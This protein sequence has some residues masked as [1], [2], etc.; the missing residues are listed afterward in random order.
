LLQIGRG[1]LENLNMAFSRPIPLSPLL[2][3]ACALLVAR[4]SL[5]RGPGESSGEFL[6]IYSDARPASLGDAYVALAEN[7]AGL[8][9]NPAGL[10]RAP[11]REITAS[12]VSW[13][14]EANFQHIA[15]THP[16]NANGEAFGL[17]LLHFD[18]GG[19]QR[20]NE[21]GISTGYN[22]AARDYS[23]TVGYGRKLGRYWAAGVSAKYIYRELDRY[24]AGAG[25]A[26]LGVLWWTPIPD[27][28][29]GATLQNLG[30]RLRFINDREP[31]PLTMRVGVSYKTW[32]D[33]VHLAADMVKVDDE[34]WKMHL[35]T[36]ITV[37]R[38][39][40]LRAGWR[41]DHGLM[42][43]YTAGVG[44]AV[45]GVTFDYAYVPFEILGNTHRITGS[46]R[47]GGPTE[48]EIHRLPV[49]ARF[50]TQFPQP[51]PDRSR[52]SSSIEPASAP[53]PPD[54]R[55]TGADTRPPS[56]RVVK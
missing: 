37:M 31:L 55:V 10:V 50:R 28:I 1:T 36:E 9:F 40:R 8:G 39:I 2:A 18:A 54:V 15:Y 33:R 16:R 7:A 53:H 51:D 6:T 29:L 26:D 38:Q 23:A 14:G 19:F 49:D 41:G 56:R 20:T 21:L 5:A 17:S 52:R 3:L 43:G 27:L 13:I 24:Q 42:R 46:V 32:L 22:L 34:K 30:S 11:S 44:L 25:A 12:Y 45:A 47:F 4:P 48:P 35:G